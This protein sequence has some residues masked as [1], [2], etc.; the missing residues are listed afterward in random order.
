MSSTRRS[1]SNRLDLLDTV[2]ELYY[3]SFKEVTSKCR[4]SAGIPLN[5]RSKG[6]LFSPLLRQVFL[7]TTE[8]TYSRGRDRNGL[9]FWGWEALL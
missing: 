6:G 8:D 3:C 2:A 5:M 4:I 9:P 7:T 1:V